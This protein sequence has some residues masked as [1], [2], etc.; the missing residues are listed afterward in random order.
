[1]EGSTNATREYKRHEKLAGRLPRLGAKLVDTLIVIVGLTLENYLSRYLGLGAVTG[2]I[3]LA[4]GVGYM[5]FADALPNGQSL[6]KK[7]FGICVIDER[8]YLNCNIYQAF[9]RNLPLQFLSILDWMFI[10]TGSRKRLGDMFAST[11]VI[12]S[13]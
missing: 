10:F 4:L 8:S 7:L 11:I 6:G 1:M 3:A 9:I 13:T 5:L 12:K 2:M